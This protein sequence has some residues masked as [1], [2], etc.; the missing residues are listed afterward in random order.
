M[1]N[2]TSATDPTK[3]ILLLMK[4]EEVIFRNEIMPD[5]DPFWVTSASP[6]SIR[7]ERESAY[8]QTRFVRGGCPWTD[9]VLKYRYCFA[10]T[11]IE[12][13]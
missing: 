8:S 13:R 11:P 6:N 7:A 10:S 1:R 3:A 12:L 2:T 5:P 9:E 4:R